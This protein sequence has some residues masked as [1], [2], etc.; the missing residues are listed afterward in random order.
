MNVNDLEKLDFQVVLKGKGEVKH[1]YTCDLLSE[2]MANALTD[3]VWFTVQSHVNIVAVAA[4]T[5]IR[6][7]V[8]CNGHEFNKDTLEKAKEEEIALFTFPLSAFEA[9]GRLYVKGLK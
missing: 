9:G 4:I 6:A 7:I 8:L 5:G 2:V 3:T 1:G